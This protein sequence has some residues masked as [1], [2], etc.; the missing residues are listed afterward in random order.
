LKPWCWHLGLDLAATSIFRFQ[1]FTIEQQQSVFDDYTN[2]RILVMEMK[3][4]HAGSIAW[5]MLQSIR[6]GPLK[7]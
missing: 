7:F 5:G 4:Q 1:Y 6:I 2:F 3:Q